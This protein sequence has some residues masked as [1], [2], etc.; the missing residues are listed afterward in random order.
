MLS[1]TRINAC[2][3]GLSA[4]QHVVL[5]VEPTGCL[6]LL[7]T[8]TLC[9]WCFMSRKEIATCTSHSPYFHQCLAPLTLPCLSFFL[10][11]VVQAFVRQAMGYLGQTPDLET[12]VELIKNLQSVTE[13]KV[14]PAVLSAAKAFRWQSV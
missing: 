7:T 3:R 9:P 11:Q 10:L 4:Q 14:W 8:P 1:N 5:W 6:L 12:K 13:G 2:Y